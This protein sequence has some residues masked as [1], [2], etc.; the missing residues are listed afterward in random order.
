MSTYEFGDIILTDFHFVDHIG[1][2]KRPGVIISKTAFNKFAGG[3]LVAMAI[4]SQLDR[5]RH[6]ENRILDLKS[7]GLAKASAFKAIITTINELAIYKKL[8]K[9]SFHDQKQLRRSL[10]SIIDLGV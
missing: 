4:T 5:L 2:K 8:G 1:Y 9:L 10:K 6:G 7:T 3:N